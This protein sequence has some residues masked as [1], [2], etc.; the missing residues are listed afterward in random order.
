M[1]SAD[2]DRLHLRSL[3]RHLNRLS[4]RIGPT[5]QGVAMGEIEDAFEGIRERGEIAG[6]SDPSV[7]FEEM[8]KLTLS[9]F[10]L[11]QDEFL[12][13]AL[14]TASIMAEAIL[15]KLDELGISLSE[16]QAFRVARSAEGGAAAIYVKSFGAGLSL[17]EKRAKASA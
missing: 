13:G 7:P 5:D 17:A 2:G 16:E 10:D 1:R 4:A 8:V 11:D 12:A 6:A 14:N 3:R 15:A 9:G